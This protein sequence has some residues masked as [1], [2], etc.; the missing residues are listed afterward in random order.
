MTNKQ[1]TYV[2][3]WVDNRKYMVWFVDGYLRCQHLGFPMTA[4]TLDLGDEETITD[5][6]IRNAI[7]KEFPKEV[8]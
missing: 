4:W 6:V 1:Y 5:E 2:T 8:K 7:R 3:Y